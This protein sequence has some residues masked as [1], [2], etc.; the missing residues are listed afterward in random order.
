[1]NKILLVIG[2]PTAVGKTEIAIRLAKKIG[3]EIISADSRQIYKELNIGTAKPNIEELSTVKHHFISTHSIHNY[4]NASMFEIEVLELL[5]TLFKQYDKVIMVG[6]SGLYI[7]AVCKGIDDLPTIDPEIRKNLTE[8]YKNEGIESL[9]MEI[10]RI[11]PQYYEKV[12]LAN[13]KRILKAL[14]V[15]Y[16]TGRP[17][18]TFLTSQIKHRNFRI[19]KVALNRKRDLLHSII[20]QRVDKMINQGLIEEAKELY[21]FKYLNALNTVGYKE[22]FAYFDNKMSLEEAIEKIKRNTR[23]YARRQISWFNRFNEYKWFDPDDSD[24]IEQISALL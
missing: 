23:Q 22:L 24:I 7:D 18:S 6:G 2:G 15:Y 9:R 21:P 8:R 13:H 16:M 20:N 19:I 17:F 1:M 3:T 5:N 4:Y 11:D 14:E 12:D 10:K